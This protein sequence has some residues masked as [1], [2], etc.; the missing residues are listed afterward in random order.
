[1]RG[2]NWILGACCG[3]THGHPAV[4]TEGVEHSN[5][6]HGSLGKETSADTS[7]GEQHVTAEH[8]VASNITNHEAAAAVKRLL[9]PAACASASTAPGLGSLPLPLD[10]IPGNDGHTPLAHLGAAEDT[11]AGSVG[12][13]HIE[14]VASS[15]TT[16]PVWS[17]EACANSAATAL[18]GNSFSRFYHRLGS[19][20]GSTLAQHTSQLSGYYESATSDRNATPAGD[21]L[22]AMGRAAGN[23]QSSKPPLDRKRRN[24]LKGTPDSSTQ[25]PY[26]VWPVPMLQPPG[27]RPMPTGQAHG[28]QYGVGQALVLPSLPDLPT[29]VGTVLSSGTFGQASDPALEL[30]CLAISRV[31]NSQGAASAAA[32]A[33][34]SATGAV[35]PASNVSMPGTHAITAAGVAAKAGSAFAADV[36]VRF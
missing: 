19:S 5:L 10:E 1:M 20:S 30:A 13:H 32:A 36:Q 17:P 25:V 11:S 26:P 33:A 9:A 3:V 21:C 31:P 12:P 2:L 14:S 16:L 28:R 22:S 29:K 15:P 24:A 6:V 35:L 8:D 23:I 7:A 18:G 27:F 34:A 4:G